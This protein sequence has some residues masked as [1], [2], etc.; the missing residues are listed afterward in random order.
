M[1]QYTQ[2]SIFIDRYVC[3]DEPDRSLS[4]WRVG[5]EVQG[6]ERELSCKGFS[7]GLRIGYEAQ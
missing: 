6:R 1:K 4:L 2:I 7:R 5:V 3:E